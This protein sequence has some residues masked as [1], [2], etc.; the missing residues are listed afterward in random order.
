VARPRILIIDGYPRRVREKLVEDGASIASNLYADTLRMCRPEIDT[1][2]VFAAD[3]DSKLPKGTELKD[4]DGAVWTGSVVSVRH[5]DDPSVAQQIAFAKAVF[6]AGITG[7]GSCFAIQIATVA[8]GGTVIQNPKG[9]EFG[10]G[11]G[12]R[13]TQA[14]RAHP[15]FAGRP[16][17]FEAA[18]IH[19]DMVAELPA[20]GEVLATNDMC[21][22]R[23]AT[24]P[25]GNTT[26]IGV[27]YHPEFSLGELGAILWR[28]RKALVR[29]GHFPD[30]DHVRDVADDYIALHQ[31]PERQDLRD[32]INVGDDL[33]NDTV[34]LTEVRNWVHTL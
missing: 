34:R 5:K 16:P 31:A 1:D 29:E 12:L 4:F 19:E 32:K 8:A 6:E 23:A 21:P 10:I 13:L 26:F 22:I 27:Q 28:Q 7:F 17:I 33:L 15:I 9:R 11:R 30:I 24:F 2:V 14:G 18:M 3:P 20:G 25:A